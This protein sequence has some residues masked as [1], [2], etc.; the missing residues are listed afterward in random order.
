MGCLMIHGNQPGPL[1]FVEQKAFVYGIIIAYFLANIFMPIIQRTMGIRLFLF[2]PRAPKPYLIPIV[3]VMCISGVYALSNQVAD[4]WVFLLSGV[5]ALAMKEFGFSIQATVL[6]LIPG[7]LIE[8]NLRT[9]LMFSDGSYLGFFSRP[10]YTG[11]LV[12]T[13]LSLWFSFRLAARTA[14]MAKNKKES[15]KKGE[16]R[17]NDIIYSDNRNV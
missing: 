7:P 3:M 1:L 9:A 12:V 2:A 10:I 17:H 11:I 6:G 8:K 13:A 16:P 4:L 15:D 5:I 14:R